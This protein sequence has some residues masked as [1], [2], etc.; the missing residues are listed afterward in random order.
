MKKVAPYTISTMEYVDPNVPFEN[1][2]ENIE[3]YYAYNSGPLEYVVVNSVKE[4]NQK[5]K[6]AEQILANTT[7]FGSATLNATET[8]ISYPASFVQR[9]AS[10]PVV[11]VSTLNSEAQVT[12]SG[13]TATGFKVK[14]LGTV[15]APV[16]IDWI[17]IAKTNPAVLEV[18]KDY[19]AAERQEMLDKVKLTPA[20]YA[21]KPK[22]AK[23]KNVNRRWKKSAL[24]DKYRPP[25][26][27]HRPPPA[28]YPKTLTNKPTKREPINRFLLCFLAPAK[29]LAHR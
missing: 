2:R 6:N 23:C 21:W 10:V 19:T 7:E 9:C 16:E 29:C 17:A 25:H 26:L 8:E 15:T 24:K 20:A 14:V 5:Q 4:L 13:K 12:I 1:I 3:Q 27:H 18:K 11:T 22:S 28:H